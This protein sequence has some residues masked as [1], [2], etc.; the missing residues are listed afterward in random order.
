VFTVLVAANRSRGNGRGL[1]MRRVLITALAA[2]SI[3]AMASTAAQAVTVSGDTFFVG[4]HAGQDCPVT[5]A[6]NGGFTNCW[7]TQTGIVA[8]PQP[9]DPTA[10]Q[11]VF[12]QDAGGD[13]E[14]NPAYQTLTGGID[15]TEFTIALTSDNH[16]LFTYV[17]GAEDPVLHYISIKQAG[18]A[19]DGGYAL[20]YDPAG[21]TSGTTYSF[22]LT[23][24]FPN[25][26]GFSHIT[27]YDSTGPVPEPAT[28]AMMLLG[29]GGIGMAMRRRRSNNGRLLQIA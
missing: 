28:W 10:S 6:Q 26:P 29:F 23:S 25:T 16:L 17:M 7:A 24:Y 22:N 21:F 11:V 13:Q 14:I 5:G 15:G 2:A 1:V 4:T 9:N 18:A 27:V 19:A 12:K 3:S 8:G 20:F